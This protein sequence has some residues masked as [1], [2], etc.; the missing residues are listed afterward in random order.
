MSKLTKN[1]LLPINIGSAS[2]E[3]RVLSVK[4][5]LAD[6]QLTFPLCTQLGE[7]VALSRRVEKHWRLVGVLVLL[8]PP[9]SRV[10]GTR[11]NRS[12]TPV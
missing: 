11:M 1:E 7:E 12:L 9:P 2:T 10:L 4:G 8:S 6:I 5:D 3:G